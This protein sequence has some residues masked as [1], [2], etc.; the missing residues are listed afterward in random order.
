MR[1]FFGVFLA[2]FTLI[3]LFLRPLSNYYEAKY[4]KDFFI[5]DER[6]MALSDKF[7]NAAEESAQSAKSVFDKIMRI[8]H[9]GLDESNSIKNNQATAS[10]KAE[11]KRDKRNEFN[12]AQRS[13]FTRS[14]TFKFR[15]KQLAG[16]KFVKFTARNRS[17]DGQGRD[18]KI[19]AF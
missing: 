18:I 13:N 17:P 15:Q 9:A 16:S 5:T 7:I 6:A 8:F 1:A 12:G 14:N 10:V 2:F 4:Q 3:A 19:R 11:H